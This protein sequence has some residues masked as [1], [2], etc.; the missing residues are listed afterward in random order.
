MFDVSSVPK[1]SGTSTGKH[2]AS[3]TV[4]KGSGTPSFNN[5]SV[6]ANAS[7]TAGPR[8]DV[9]V[10]KTDAPDPAAVGGTLTYTFVVGNAGPSAAAS[11]VFTV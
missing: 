7:V 1:Y 10:V 3:S 6:S 5:Y 4:R 9:S 2:N 11:V 8:A